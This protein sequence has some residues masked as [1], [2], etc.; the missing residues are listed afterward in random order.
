MNLGL[1]I[2]HALN[3]AELPF[4]AE[5]LDIAKTECNSIIDDLW[6]GVKANFRMGR[7]TLVTVSGSD[8]YLL[9]KNFDGFLKNSLQSDTIRYQY[10]DPEDF[11]R[12]VRLK[13][14]TSG[15]AYL[16]TFGDMTG[17]DNQ[18]T[19]GSKI[20]ALS[21]LANKTTSNVN[22][23]AG[24]QRV[25][26]DFDVFDLNDVG[27]R[28]KVSGDSESYK[29]SKFLNSKEITLAEK[30]R[31]ATANNASY[32]IGDVGVQVNVQGYVS[33]EIDSENI[34]LNGATAVL[35]KKTFST[36]ISISK[37]D[38]TGGKVTVTNEANTRTVASLAGGE[39]EIE[40]QTVLFWP[41]PE[42]DGEELM[43]RYW[44]KHPYLWLDSE[45]PLIPSKF[46]NLIRYKLEQAMLEWAGV[47]VP[48]SLLNKIADGQRRF[49]D[50]AEDLSLEDT[51]PRK[52]GH[53]K[54]GESFYW[55]KDED[56]A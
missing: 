43:F 7:G 36:L 4:D 10:K 30:Y 41:V 40:R 49:E 46:H 1:L 23:T 28:L 12:L 35:S 2:R 52:D 9:P 32:A 29:I 42:D 56:I 15:Q 19:S 26:S 3:K 11:F 14:G 48:A 6:Y 50:E 54:L 17:V 45:R 33:G 18:L 8:E 39:M 37:S 24:S 51:N 22:V 27:L 5:H 34:E 55:D 16:Y 20:R 31:G 38:R 25:T 21:G 47:E 13:Q 44:L 53:S